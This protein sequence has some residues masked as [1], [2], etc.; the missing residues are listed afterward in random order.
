MASFEQID[1][2]IAHPLYSP[3]EK[4]TLEQ[5]PR[6]ESLS[7]PYQS[8][9]RE[10]SS[11]GMN[12]KACRRTSPGKVPRSKSRNAKRRSSMAVSMM[13]DGE[14]SHDMTMNAHCTF[15]VQSMS[16]EK[17]QVQW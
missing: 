17:D 2:T 8:T 7:M 6:E 10:C 11:N 4:G 13:D 14:A 15:K 12:R 1:E 9:R 5:E 3:D 16:T